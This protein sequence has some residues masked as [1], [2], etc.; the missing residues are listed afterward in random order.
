[1][2]FMKFLLFSSPDPTQRVMWAIGVRRPSVVNFL[3][4]L[5]LWK[6]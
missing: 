1:M 5:L 3:K 4:N 2:K 6:Y